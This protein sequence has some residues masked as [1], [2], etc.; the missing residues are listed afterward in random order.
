MNASICHF[1]LLAYLGSVG[2]YIQTALESHVCIGTSTL[3]LVTLRCID[4]FDLT[5]PAA[6]SRRLHL[7]VITS[8]SKDITSVLYPHCTPQCMYSRLRDTFCA[9]NSPGEFIPPKICE[10]V[11]RGL[12]QTLHLPILAQHLVMEAGKRGYVF[13]HIS[14]ILNFILN[15]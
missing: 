13:L 2:T 8:N 11:F 7:S 15:N 14:Y 5:Q 1:I 6:A 3:R 4:I 10:E 9:K 12:I